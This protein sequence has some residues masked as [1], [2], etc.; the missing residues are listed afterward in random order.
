MKVHQVFKGEVN[1]W[2]RTTTPHDGAAC[3][4]LLPTNTPV[5]LFGRQSDHDD[6]YSIGLCDPNRALTASETLFAGFDPAA[7]APG[8]WSPE[9]VVDPSEPTEEAVA[10]SG[11]E[12]PRW[13]IIVV[14][15]AGAVSLGGL[16][17]RCA[18]PVDS[19]GDSNSEQ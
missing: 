18:S 15:I 2:Q 4:I 12:I 11:D 6:L 3:G 5:I 16:V 10:P 8:G 19:I 17:K 7:P 1:E 13:L 14:A 9:A